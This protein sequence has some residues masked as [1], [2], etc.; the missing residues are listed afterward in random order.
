MGTLNVKANG[1]VE[2][3]SNFLFLGFPLN[4]TSV[5]FDPEKS[6]I[7]YSFEDFIMDPGFIV[8]GSIAVSKSGL[9]SD[10]TA[11]VGIPKHVPIIGG[12]EFVGQKFV[13]EGKIIPIIYGNSKTSLLY[14]MKP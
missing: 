2:A 6:K 11:Y 4:E 7:K 10:T 5:I 14:M 3:I 8:D 12:Y 9:S 1:Y 13:I